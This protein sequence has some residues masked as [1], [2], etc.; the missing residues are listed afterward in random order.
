MGHLASDEWP[1]VCH[2]SSVELNQ[3]MSSSVGHG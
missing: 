2:V 1:T 3:T